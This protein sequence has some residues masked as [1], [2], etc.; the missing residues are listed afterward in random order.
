MLYFCADSTNNYM[1]LLYD[2]GIRLFSLATK[3]ASP[4]NERAALINKGRLQTWQK[5][6]AIDWSGEVIWVHCASLG[7]FEQGRP[8][9]EAI[10]K[11]NPNVKIVLTFFSPS[12]YEVR[13]SYNMADAVVYLPSDTKS[14]ALRFIKTVNPSKVFFV[15]YE[16]WFHYFNELKKAGIPLYMVSAIFRDNQVF[17]KSYGAWFRKILGCVTRFYVQDEKSEKLL[18]SIGLQNTVV[19][20]DTRFDRVSAIAKSA[21]DVPVAEAFSKDAR[22]LVAGSSWP[23]DEAILA[24]YINGAPANVKFIIAPHEVHDGHVSQLVKRFT[25]PVVRFSQLQGE[26][27]SSA[28]VLIIDTIGLLS[29]IYRYGSVAYIGGG[30][31]KGIHNTLEAAT[32]NMPVIFG[33]NHKKFKEAVDLLSLGGGF[34]IANQNDFNMV[35]A[36]LWDAHASEN[37]IQAGQAAGAYVKSMCGAT[38]LIMREILGA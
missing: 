28:R 31:G 2:A 23:A 10:R 11:E 37:L 19:A 27:P 38:P 6:S 14:N 15:K 21:A 35:M 17:F 33:P 18:H 29:S 26:V 20:G 7:E 1:K 16:Y 34:T 4:F 5:L 3:L 36:K 8:L 12:G 32:Y 24:D 13:K 22:V 30:F 25:V 9:I